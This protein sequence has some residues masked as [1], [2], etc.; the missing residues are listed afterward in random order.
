[1]HKTVNIILLIF[2]MFFLQINSSFAGTRKIKIISQDFENK[3]LMPD[4][5][6]CEFI[7]QDKSPQLSFSKAPTSTQSFALI[8][9]DKDA[10]DKNFV[11]WIIFNIPGSSSD[12]EQD[13]SRDATLENGTK[14][15]TNGTEQIGYFGP[16]PPPKETHRYVFN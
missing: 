3:G 5:N 7:G 6:A 8:M 13:I 15:G 2:I 11:H 4:V 9:F 1:M 10:P 14:Q 12:L 16:C